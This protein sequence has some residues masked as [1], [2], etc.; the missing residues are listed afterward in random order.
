MSAYHTPSAQ[1]NPFELEPGAKTPLN[2]NG[3]TKKLIN[4]W[5]KLSSSRDIR[6]EIQENA[7]SSK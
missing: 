5:Y 6:K 3:E 4:I 1:A 7:S 2:I